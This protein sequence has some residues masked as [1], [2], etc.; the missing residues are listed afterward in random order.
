MD[1]HDRPGR[2]VSRR[3]R[4]LRLAVAKKP[5]EWDA[6][7]VYDVPAGYRWATTNEVFAEARTCTEEHYA[8]YDQAGWMGLEWPPGSGHKRLGFVCADSLQ[9]RKTHHAWHPIKS[10][11]MALSL[12]IARG[13]Y[14]AGLICIRM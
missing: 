14:F 10:Y 2:G 12:G 7:R 13:W 1:G 4:R 9:T 3:H 6:T 5:Q 11:P 8:Y